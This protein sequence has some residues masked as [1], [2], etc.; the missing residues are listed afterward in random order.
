LL[1]ALQESPD[2]TQPLRTLSLFSDCPSSVA[3][4][5]ERRSCCAVGDSNFALDEKMPPGSGST[6]I[7]VP[8]VPTSS[9]TGREIARHDRAQP[10]R[11]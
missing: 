7:P 2:E 9:A 10:G 1:P 8:D 6:G 5:A 4:M 3:Q 11:H